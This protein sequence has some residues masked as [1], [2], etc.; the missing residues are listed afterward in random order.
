MRFKKHHD[1]DETWFIREETGEAVWELPEG[2][3]VE[4]DTDGP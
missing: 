2:G 3:W 4:N 1:A